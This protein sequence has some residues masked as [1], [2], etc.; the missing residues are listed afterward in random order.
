MEIHKDKLQKKIDTLSEQLELVKYENRFLKI[1]IDKI[2]TLQ[3]LKIKD[4][5]SIDQDIFVSSLNSVLSDIK[6]LVG[7]GQIEDG[8]LKL[9][10]LSRNRFENEYNECIL[11]RARLNDIKSRERIDSIQEKQILLE[12]NKIG[13]ALLDLVDLIGKK[14]NMPFIG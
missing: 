14:L 10:E 12:K 9:E 5:V 11:L 13:R 1:L 2:L 7:G 3:I 8:V 6:T 4:I